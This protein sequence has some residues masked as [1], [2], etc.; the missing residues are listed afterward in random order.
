M[1]TESRG[2]SCFS[3]L[4]LRQTHFLSLKF[5]IFSLLI[6]LGEVPWWFS[7]LRIWCCY[8]CGA[9]LIPGPELSHAA[10]AAKTETKVYLAPCSK[11]YF[12]CHCW[13]FLTFWGN[14][15][16]STMLRSSAPYT[17]PH[18][19]LSFHLWYTWPTAYTPFQKAPNTTCSELAGTNWVKSSMN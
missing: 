13:Q 5:N 17:F 8:C 6:Y 15:Y 19:I 18:S 7:G 1:R 16:P 11:P 2:P 4:H 12:D 9:A 10:G 14:E 3:H